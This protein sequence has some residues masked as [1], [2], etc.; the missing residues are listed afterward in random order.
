MLSLRKVSEQLSRMRM[1][2]AFVLSS[3]LLM[4][5]GRLYVGA[6]ITRTSVDDWYEGLNKP[7]F[8]PPN[9][10]FAPVW[11]ILYVV[12]AISAWL[13]WKNSE[14]KQRTF[15]LLIFTVQLFFN[16]A[17]S[18]LFF[19]VK[20]PSLALTEIFILFALCVETW[21]RFRNINSHSGI[22]FLPYVLWTAFAVALNIGIVVL[23]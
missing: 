17:W 7:L 22:L 13:A 20:S 14:K 19:G 4:T 2:S 5:M 1:L 15:A 3:F 21:R 6:L 16:L 11:T 12:I 23:N 10:V 8:T 9:W 18:F